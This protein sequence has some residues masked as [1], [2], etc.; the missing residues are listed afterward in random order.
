MAN[1]ATTSAVD[2]LTMMAGGTEVFETDGVTVELRGLTFAESQ[3]L[4]SQYK[5]D[6]TELTFQAL[7]LGL[8][9]PKLDA[10]QLD[11]LRNGRP[12]PLMKIA[13][14]IITISGMGEDDGPLAP[15]GGS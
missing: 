2:F 12:G 4:V 5:D 8:V 7:M 15:G 10:A 3:R 6:N 11:Q 1:K 9:E 14:R 13:K